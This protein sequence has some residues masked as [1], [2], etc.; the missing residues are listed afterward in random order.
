MR[1]MGEVLAESDASAPELGG[2]LRV[3]EDAVENLSR[4]QRAKREQ[5]DR[6]ENSKRAFVRVI[7][8]R[9][10][11]REAGV[12]RAVAMLL[13]GGFMLSVN[14]VLDMLG[15]CPARFAEESQEDE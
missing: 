4:E 13:V 14:G 11:G 10:R 15:C 6:D 7:T 5:R 8:T 12:M 1:R 9:A 3:D 2:A